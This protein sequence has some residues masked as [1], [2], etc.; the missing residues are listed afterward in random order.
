MREEYIIQAYSPSLNRTVR[1]FNL[2][3]GNPIITDQRLA[4]LTADS[5]SARLN[6]QKHLKVTDWQPKAEWQKTGI[7]TID[8]YTGHTG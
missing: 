4:D 5:F 3:M 6:Q 8:G 1:E 2:A 7:E